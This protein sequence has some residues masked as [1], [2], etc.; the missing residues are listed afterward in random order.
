[1]IV[2]AGL[3]ISDVVTYHALQSFLTTRVDQQLEAA[4]FPVG[5][6]LLS[7]SGLGPQVPAAP[8]TFTVPHGTNRTS[9]PGSFRNGGGLLSPRGGNA[10]GVLIP[11]G[12]YG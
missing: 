11:P 4:A 10:R 5:R 7:S 2:A 9:N 6:A 3:M 8:R 12:T 1:V